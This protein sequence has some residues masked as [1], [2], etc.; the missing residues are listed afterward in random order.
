MLELLGHTKL[1]E[2]GTDLKRVKKRSREDEERRLREEES[3]ADPT[4]AGLSVSISRE[5][6][7]LG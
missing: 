6:K 3:R 7:V 4:F 1:V 2:W 5:G